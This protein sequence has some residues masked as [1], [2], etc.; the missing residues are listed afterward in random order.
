M[1]KF[2]WNLDPALLHL[3]PI[4]IRYYSLL[5]ALVFIGGYWLLR[6]QITRGGGKRED[7]EDFIVYG[8]LGV[9]VGA[10]VGHILFY[11]LDKFLEDPLWLFRIWEGGLASHGATLGLF[12]A[13]WLFTWRRKIPFLEGADRFAFSAALGATLVRAGNFLNSEI[14]GRPTDGTWGV[15]FVRHD[16]DNVVYRHPSQ[17][18]E[19]VLGLLVLAILYVA[20]RA[21]GQEKRPRGALIAFFFIFY[22]AGR[23]F[24]EFFKAYQTGLYEADGLTMGQ[25]LSIPAFA[26][27]VGLL[28][29]AFSKRLPVGWNSG[30]GPVK[31]AALAGEVADPSDDAD[32]DIDE[33]FDG[34]GLKKRKP[35]PD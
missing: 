9:L 13:M 6:W 33:E 5:F 10:R 22:F 17:L 3:G 14:V 31:K 2:E 29:W 28:L 26:F 34:G 25:Y 32:Q 15:Y 21:L 18:Y 27:G 19:F 20:D 4:E 8:V 16:G 30:G 35:K 24:V 23:F 7:A 11:D 12:V 1:P